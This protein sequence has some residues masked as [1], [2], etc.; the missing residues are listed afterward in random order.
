MTQIRLQKYNRHWEKEFRY[1][2]PKPRKFLAKLIETI[3]QRQIEE[4]TG[5]RRT[6]KTVLLFQ[7]INHLIEK[8]VNPFCI[9]YFTFDEEMITIE[10]LLQNFSQQTGVDI[11]K[12]KLFIFL[13]E[14]QK[15]S[16]FAGQLKI[17][18]DLYPNLK[19]F[20][21]GSTS[22]FIKKKT[23]ESLAGR[24]FSLFLPPLNFK[25]YL[26]FK[27]KEDI[28]AKPLAFAAEIEKEFEVF[29]SSQ[30][31]ESVFMNDRDTRRQY[32]TNIMKKIIFED[33]P[34]GFSIDNPEILW[35]MVKMIAAKPG[36]LVDYQQ[37]SS[38]I[39]I[40]NKTV[41]LYFFYLE[42]SFLVRKIF[43]FSRNLISSERKLKKAYLASPSFAWALND[44][45]ETG[46]LVENYVVS[47]S[48]CR[49]F[50]RDAYKHE[51]DLVIVDDDRIIP[52]EVK[53]KNEVK[54]S[55]Y[56]NLLLFCRH[57]KCQEAIMINKIFEEKTMNIDNILFKNL[58]VYWW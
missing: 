41:S 51:I 4:L 9:L 30:F 5:L 43:N 50:W 8:G 18:Y 21:S 16:G 2:Y 7:V 6:G 11:K 29:L 42:E 14:I 45:S 34:Q 39:G 55:E 49:F 37:F 26:Y 13:D 22:L 40:S 19:F 36:L 10:E 48:D 25:E 17:Y 56:K 27:E 54:E 15:L 44:F 24:V 23:Q 57:F 31:I 20:I 28:N 58:P 1:P 33:I 35:R 3:G 12:D 38:E 32:L 47:Q 52:L 46:T 53:Y